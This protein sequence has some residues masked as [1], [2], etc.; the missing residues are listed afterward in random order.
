MATRSTTPDALLGHLRRHGRQAAGALTAALDISRPTLARAVADLPEVVRLGRTRATQYALAR[1]IRGESSWPLYRLDGAARVV[2]LGTLMALDRDEFAF[3]ASHASPSLLHAPFGH[4]VFP[5]LPWFLDDLRPGGFLGRT[6][7]HRMAQSLQLPSDLARWNAAH[8]VTALLHGGSAQSGD[9]IL[10][11]A[12]LQRALRECDVPPDLVDAQDRPVIYPRMAANV[13]EGD[14]PGSSPGGEQAKFTATVGTGGARYAAI[15]KFSIADDGAAAR[16]WADLLRCEA[17]ASRVLVAH[18]LSAASSELLDVDGQVFLE[19]RRFDRTEGT[20]GRSGFVSLAASAAAFHGE[21]SIPWC[22]L[23]GRLHDDG[24]LDARGA[25]DLRRLYWFGALIANSDMHLGNAGLLLTDVLPLQLA[26]AYDM[27]PMWLR[28]GAQGHVAI[29]DYPIPIPDAGQ[30]EAWRWAATAA[31]DFWR[32]AQRL[33]RIEPAMH[34]FAADMER[35]I[36]TTAARF[37][38]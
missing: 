32:Q 10:G 26:P 28:P 18:G 21:A 31:I 4:G 29:R 19:S 7:A 30:I 33:E 17:L 2:A 9:L 8:V 25:E 20:L 34:A 5:D 38:S 1:D 13:L 14:A 22:R 12:A 11:D 16:R 6:F 36:G 23:A 35:A 3:T 24:W 27:L 37:R 15:V